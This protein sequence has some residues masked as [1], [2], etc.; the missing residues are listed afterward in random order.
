[1]EVISTS[2]MESSP[3]GMAID[4][5]GHLWVAFCHGSCVICYDPASGDEL[6]RVDLP[7]M[8]TTACAFGGENL[9]ELYVTTGIH[10]S[11]VEED[12]G[13]LFR[14]TGLGVRGLPSHAFAG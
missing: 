6:K 5:N 2:N 14:I 1:R 11:E 12:A 3:D 10:K 8:E 9:D 7:C 4:E 13:R